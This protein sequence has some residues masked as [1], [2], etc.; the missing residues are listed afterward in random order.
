MFRHSHRLV[1]NSVDT[2]ADTH[3]FDARLDMD[4][5]GFLADRLHHNGVSN[6]DNRGFFGD[7]LQAT[8]ILFVTPTAQLAQLIFDGILQATSSAGNDF[9]AATIAAGAQFSR[10]QIGRSVAVTNDRRDL[11][12]CVFDDRRNSGRAVA[13]AASI[14]EWTCLDRPR[15]RKITAVSSDDSFFDVTLCAQHR[16]DFAS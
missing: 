7:L 8:F 9:A 15:D 12:I 1:Q 13:I 4:I 3:A 16:R 5:R 14:A 2:V 6:S 10:G 11:T